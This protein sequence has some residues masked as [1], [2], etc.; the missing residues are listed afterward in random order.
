MMILL[1]FFFRPELLS[2]HANKKV[3]RNG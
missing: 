1:Q 2:L 3:A